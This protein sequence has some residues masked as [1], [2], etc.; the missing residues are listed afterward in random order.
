MPGRDYTRAFELFQLS[1]DDGYHWKPQADGLRGLAGLQTLP[2][3]LWKRGLMEH[4]DNDFVQGPRLEARVFKLDSPRHIRTGSPKLEYGP[5]TLDT[6]KGMHTTQSSILE[7]S[8]RILQLPTP[9]TTPSSSGALF[10][11]HMPD[12]NLSSS[13]TA[14]FMTARETSMTPTPHTI[15][16]RPLRV[17]T[18]NSVRSD[19]TNTRRRID[20]LVS[21]NSPLPN[22]NSVP[23]GSPKHVKQKSRG[24]KSL[25]ADLEGVE[26]ET[27]IE[28]DDE[29]EDV[30]VLMRGLSMRNRNQSHQELAPQASIRTLHHTP[31]PKYKLA[32]LQG[33]ADK[34]MHAPGVS[35]STEVV[36]A[37]VVDTTPPRRKRKLRHSAGDADLRDTVSHSEH[38]NRT[39]YSDTSFATVKMSPQLELP[40][41]NPRVRRMESDEA[42]IGGSPVLR[43]PGK[44]EVCYMDDFRAR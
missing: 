31:P 4:Q 41:Q 14:S 20:G 30:P 19:A 24:Q 33:S 42:E 32:G 11:P 23:T 27:Q 22:I 9:D 6:T 16:R 36:E 44:F 38:S 18:S 5:P 43:H 40:A 17:D 21:P 7:S 29:T 15:P 2:G 39:S 37:L 25:R 3:D 12:A 8:K 1:L 26:D 13:Q 35:S 28:A 34:A 10:Q